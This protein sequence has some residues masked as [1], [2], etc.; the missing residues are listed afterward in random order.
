M[1]SSKVRTRSAS[2]LWKV[3]NLLV[4]F[5]ALTNAQDHVGKPVPDYVHGDECL[6]CHRNDIGNG[7]QKNA[8]GTTVRQREDAADLVKKLNPPAEVEFFL[9]SRHHVRYLKK[10]GYGKFAI[11]NPQGQWDKDKFADHC[12]WCHATGV[13]VKTRA[14]SAF[15]LNCYTC[16]GVVD[17]EHTADTAKMWLSKK[18]RDDVKAI[19]SICAQCHLREGKS[20]STG[21]PYPNNFVAGDNLFSDYQVDFK[22]V[23]DETLNA[24]DR[25]VLRN[26]RD[27]IVNN[28][29]V[30]CLSCHRI[31]AN[32]TAKHRRVLT[33]AAC[34]DC[35]NAQGPK[36]AVKAHEVH[37]ALC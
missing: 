14:F 16:H 10:S 9:G 21:L 27:V 8:H 37:S 32:D 22:R 31:H 17:L 3:S 30:T 26:V 24:G 36:K 33:S 4:F 19:T 7:W 28:S 11:Q 6:F 18:R 23:D 29:D 25:H 34:L 15:G 13:D 2:R 1:R 20:K 35:H 12:A 5:C